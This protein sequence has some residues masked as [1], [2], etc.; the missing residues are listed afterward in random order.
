MRDIREGLEEM[1]AHL[2]SEGIP[3]ASTSRSRRYDKRCLAWVDEN[4][5]YELTYIGSPETENR[6]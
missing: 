3:R 4:G 6:K 1:I 5:D 2:K